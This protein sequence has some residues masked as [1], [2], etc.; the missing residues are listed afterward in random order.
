MIKVSTTFTRAAAGKP[1]PKPGFSTFWLLVFAIAI[2]N[3][4]ESREEERRRKGEQAQKPRRR[5][6]W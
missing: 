5:R 6:Q 4:A 2:L 3:D 1:E